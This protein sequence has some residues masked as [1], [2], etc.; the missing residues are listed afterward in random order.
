[1]IVLRRLIPP[2]ALLTV[3][4]G[5]VAALTALGSRAP[6]D[7]PRHGLAAWL[8]TTAPPDVLV[9][10]LRW[11][12]LA[13]AWWLLAG[14]LVYVGASLTRIPGA[15]RA[16]R[17]AALPAVR[18]AVDATLVASFVTGSLLTPAVAHGASA[19]ASAGLPPATAV[20]DGHAGGLTS[21]PAEPGATPTTTTATPAT[22][23]GAPPA[24][25]PTPP[26]RDASVVVMPGD[27]LW[28]LSARRYAAA[29]GRPRGDVGDAEVAPYW[30]VVCERNRATLASGDPDLIYP[31]ERVVLP[32]VG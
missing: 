28:E 12:A 1:M 9:V 27:N 6:F 14:T 22:S 18:R 24:P 25:A 17:W 26:P 11:V 23:T 8:H 19:T 15:V 2:V 5:A 3:E 30:S 29:A 7:G 4:G 32:P 10:V 20:R 16:V 21:L 13:G 31:G